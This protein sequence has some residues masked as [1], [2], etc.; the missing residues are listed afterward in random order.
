[1][2]TAR[3]R[4]TL[5][6]SASGSVSQ[7]LVPELQW[8]QGRGELLLRILS[9]K[10]WMTIRSTWQQ[11]LFLCLP[12]HKISR[13]KHQQNMLKKAWDAGMITKRKVRKP[14][15]LLGYGTHV[16]IFVFKGVIEAKTTLFIVWVRPLPTESNERL[17][18]L[19][20]IA[21]HAWSRPLCCTGKCHLF[22]M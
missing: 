15:D 7:K 12:A 22:V 18:N 20:R 2:Q 5:H 13:S 14:V 4:E 3:E 1:M 17:T 10:H 21:Q 11:N 8:F 19:L 16:L 9:E 6:L